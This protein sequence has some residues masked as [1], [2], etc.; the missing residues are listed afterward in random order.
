M[1]NLGDIIDGRND[2]DVRA[3]VPTRRAAVPEHLLRQNLEDLALMAGIVE[4]TRGATPVYHCLG[5]HDLN[6]PREDALRVLG[7]NPGRAAYFTKKLPRGWRLIVLDTTDVNPRYA[8]PGSEAQL[9]GEAYV[10]DAKAAAAGGDAARVL[11]APAPDDVCKPW[12]GGV[13]DAQLAW[14]EKTLADAVTNEERVLIASHCALSPTSAR[15]GMAAWNAR[16]LARTLEAR[17]MS[18]RSLHD[19]VGVVNADP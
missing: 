15:P 19:R 10:R 1:L 13:G 7:G 12:G 11:G 6:V 14:L 8:T 17:S 4:E 2:D 5:N 9:A 18:H 3:E 16:E